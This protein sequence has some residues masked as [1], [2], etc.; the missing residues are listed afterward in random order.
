MV[1]R[2]RGVALGAVV[3]AAAI[4]AAVLG[5]L[6]VTGQGDAEPRRSAAGP[7]TPAR[8]AHD[9]DASIVLH[10]TAGGDLVFTLPEHTYLSVW[11]PQ[12]DL[13]REPREV[14]DDEFRLPHRDPSQV[15]SGR[16]V[17]YV[18]D[19]DGVIVDVVVLSN[20]RE[21][22]GRLNP[23]QWM[24]SKDGVQLVWDQKDKTPWS[25]S[26]GEEEL[27]RD[28]PGIFFDPVSSGE[29]GYY[30]MENVEIVT[31]PPDGYYFNEPWKAEKGDMYVAIVP[32]YDATLIG[33]PVA[34][35][36]NQSDP[37]LKLAH[38]APDASDLGGP[39]SR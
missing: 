31:V 29:A 3:I 15:A 35:V 10:V 37:G 12:T 23:L 28:A 9:V 14:G 30:A 18:A 32:G 8:P 2:V 11:D 1:N 13:H 4:V 5:V 21:G 27:A 39:L 22:G 24:L 26:R 25:V 16:T 20:S 19:D 36:G 38:S 7:A 17:F 33:Q 6:D 34:S